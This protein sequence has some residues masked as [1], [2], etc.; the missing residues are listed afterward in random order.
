MEVF[1]EKKWSSNVNNYVVIT[2]EH[3]LTCRVPIKP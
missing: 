3:V 1:I 2:P